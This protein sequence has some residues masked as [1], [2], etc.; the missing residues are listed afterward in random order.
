MILRNLLC[1]LVTV[2]FVPFCA[3]ASDEYTNPIID[4]DYSDPDVIRVG[5]DFYLTASSFNSVPGLPILHSR[6]LVNWRIIGHALQR[7]PPFDVFARPQ[8]GNGVRELSIGFHN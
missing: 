4:A 8:H 1:L 5:D 2:L 7:Q 6:D 3:L